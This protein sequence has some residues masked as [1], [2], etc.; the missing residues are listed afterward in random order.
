MEDKQMDEH[1]ASLA[2]GGYESCVG[3]CSWLGAL[4]QHALVH[5]QC[6]LRLPAAVA[7]IDDGVVRPYLRLC[8]LQQHHTKPLNDQTFDSFAL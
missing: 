8:A 6:V 2:I 3:G 4:C 5:L 7:G 1:L